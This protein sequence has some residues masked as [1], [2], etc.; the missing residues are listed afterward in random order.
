ML[1]NERKFFF[2]NIV[3]IS[4]LVITLVSFYTAYRLKFGNTGSFIIL[5]ATEYTIFFMAYLIAW[6]YMS[7][8]RQ[9]YNTKRILQLRYEALDV[10]RS[11]SICI[12]IAMIPAFFIREYPLSRMFLILLWCIQ[13]FSLSTIRIALRLFIRYIRK[14][15]YNPRQIL[16]IGKNYR[17]EVLLSNIFN[18]KEYGLNIAGYIDVHNNNNNRYMKN[19]DYLGDI[20]RLETILRESIIDLVF[21]T[22]PLKSLYSEIEKIIAI[23]EKMGVEVEMHAELFKVKISKSG[24]SMFGGMKTIN[25]Y[26]SP[27]TDV[28]RIIVKRII[29]ISVSLTAIVILSPLFLITGML[30]KF[31]SQGPIFFTQKRVGYNGRMFKLLKFRT[32]IKE[33]E[34]MKKNLMSMNELDGPVF[35]I[36]QDP[37]ITYVGAFLRKTSVDELPQLFNVLKGDMSLVG[38]RPPLPSEVNLYSIDDH[39]RLSVQQGIT[40]LWQVSGRNNVPFD[41]WM[42]LDREY[43]DKWSVW[44]DIKILLKTILVVLSTRSGY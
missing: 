31:T 35:K 39:R 12:V 24:I 38:P 30:I 3:S 22:L 26:T 14:K 23:C 44:L 7:K 25:F 34:S 42:E 37:R 36:K 29:D 8:R 19:I 41:K 16:I 21:I 9:E 33:A 32:M 6:V 18:S 1:L 43:I 27:Q 28:G 20:N 17:S 4:D 13:T 5:P 10:V 11:T 2:Q 40:G 15:G